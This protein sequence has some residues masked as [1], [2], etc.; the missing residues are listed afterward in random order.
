MFRSFIS[1]HVYVLSGHV[2]AKGLF[3]DLQNAMKLLL[4]LATRFIAALGT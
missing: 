1:E 4:L 3:H 2:A